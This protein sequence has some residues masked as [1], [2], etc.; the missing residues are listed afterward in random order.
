VSAASFLP[1]GD[2]SVLV[3]RTKPMCASLPTIRKPVADRPF[4]NFKHFRSL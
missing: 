2:G 3:T 4:R 1:G